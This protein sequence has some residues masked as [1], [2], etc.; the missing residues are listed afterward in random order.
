VLSKK[1]SEK[2]VEVKE[3]AVRMEGI[4]FDL[5]EIPKGEGN[6]KLNRLGTLKLAERG[7]KRDD[8]EVGECGRESHF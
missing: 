6:S 8:V 1:K 4:L 5:K 2:R 3:V 7:G